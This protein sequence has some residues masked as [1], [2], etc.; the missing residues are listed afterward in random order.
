M[1]LSRIYIDQ[2]LA[3]GTTVRLERDHSHY[4]RNVLRL[5]NGAAIALFNGSDHC[6]YQAR[7]RFEGKNSAAEIISSTAK[8]T[9]SRL[10][11]N[12]ILAVSRSDRIDF[13]I[14]KCTE[15]GVSRISI[16][17]AQHSQNPIKP[18]QM[19]KR[20]GH[21][22]TIAI[23]ACEQCGRHRIPQIGF[24]AQPET[25]L[26]SC[27][28]EGA[29]FVLDFNGPA[30]PAL[31][32][33][34]PPTYPISLLTGPEGGLTDGE[35]ALTAEYGYLPAQLGPRVLRTETAAITGLAVIQSLWGDMAG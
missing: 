16:F 1:R 23:N 22:K 32:T 24:Y 25:M 20:L 5:K 34:T 11:S 8:E 17:N 19:D 27:N 30:L 31:L 28:H 18:A 35:L 29:K 10:D 21:W 13:S 2:P 12:V 4:V 33:A 9:D 15:L 14:Q 6:D 26:T 3:C 7:L